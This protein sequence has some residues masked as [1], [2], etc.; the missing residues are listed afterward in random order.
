MNWAWIDVETTGLDP[1]NDIILEIGIIITD[2]DLNE[3]AAQAWIIT[4]GES[5]WALRRMDDVVREMHTTNGLLNEL[6][7]EGVPP[8]VA[9]DESRAFIQEHDAFGSPMCGS[10]VHFD[11]SMLN[12]N[13]RPLLE[14]FS[15]RNI[16]VSTIKELSKS[17][18]AEEDWWENNREPGV[19]TH[20]S[21]GDL[22][23]SIAELQ[24]YSQWFRVWSRT[25]A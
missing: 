9:S 14:S 6:E 8:W 10:T 18:L 20:R 25:D 4:P 23:D 19:K 15:Y 2:T 17:W 22:R 5:R 1:I 16:D 11:R 24:H 3:I 21:L 12:A 7:G 13:M